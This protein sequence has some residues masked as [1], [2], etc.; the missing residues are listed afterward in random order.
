MPFL[1]ELQW[2]FKIGLLKVNENVFFQG[3]ED[4]SFIGYNRRDEQIHDTM[5]KTA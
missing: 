1:N 2:N 4:G 5:Q 3:R